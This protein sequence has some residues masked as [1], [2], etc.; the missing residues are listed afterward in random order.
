MITLLALISIVLLIFGISYAVYIYHWP[1]AAG[2]TWLS[3]FIGAG[4]TL[5]G[6]AAAI[7]VILAFSGLL[8]DYWYIALAGPVA[9][10]YT[11][12][13]MIVGQVIKYRAQKRANRDYQEL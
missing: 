2:W 5:I 3:V 6:E 1:A 8:L 12:L 11:G 7:L 13:P 4:F 10:S 9:F